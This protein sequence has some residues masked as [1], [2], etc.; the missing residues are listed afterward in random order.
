MNCISLLSI[1][2]FIC[3]M[4]H[5]SLYATDLSDS[6]YIVQE[7]GVRIIQDGKHTSS[8]IVSNS[9]SGE[10]LI[11]ITDMPVYESDSIPAIF[12]LTF[13]SHANSKKT[14]S[15]TTDDCEE[16]C[17]G[18]PVTPLLST[19]WGQT[20]PFNA[21]LPE[22]DGELSVAGCV[23]TAMAQVVN[24][25][26]WP[27]NFNPVP[28]DIH[29]PGNYPPVYPVDWSSIP[30]TSFDYD[31][32]LNWYPE[33]DSRE[34]TPNQEAVAKLTYYCAQS[35]HTHYGKTSD[36]IFLNLPYVMNEMFGYEMAKSYYYPSATSDEEWGARL[37]EELAIGHPVLYELQPGGPGYGH[38]CVIDGYLDGYMFHF[39]FGWDGWL[40]GYYDIRGVVSEHLDYHSTRSICG[41][42]P[43]RTYSGINSVVPDASE[44]MTVYSINGSVVYNGLSEGFD[45][46]KV[47]AGLYI[48]RTTDS[49]RK[50]FF[51][52]NNQ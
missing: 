19:K 16:V 12:R 30:P 18:N 32:M 39:N 41:V 24:Y 47:P 45:K 34:L 37:Y 46:T 44:T 9:P 3:A 38:A 13:L 27:E 29:I 21:M 23:A 7:E 1:V 43:S 40:D 28:H 8:Y 49:I 50:I 20:W 4:C 17:F 52:G 51:P 35:M 22:T 36:A 33:T 25:Y 26:R 14:T 31:L 48:I 11:G 6:S 10:N 15:Q 5:T 2:T 42:V